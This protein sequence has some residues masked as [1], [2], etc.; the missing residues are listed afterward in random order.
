MQIQ[1]KIGRTKA[2]DFGDNPLPQLPVI[3]NN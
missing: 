1:E 2:R 3:Q